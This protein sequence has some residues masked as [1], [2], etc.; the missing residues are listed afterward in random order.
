MAR[1]TYSSEREEFVGL[2]DG[3]NQREGV[4]AFLEKRSSGVEADFM[5]EAV[6]LFNECKSAAGGR[7]GVATLNSEKTLNSLSLEMI[8]LL[9]PQLD[10]W[11]EDDGI[12]AVVIRGAG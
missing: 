9:N 11:Q 3:E 12:D 10:L 7:L 5:S 8:E 4:N 1:S 2:F 6:V